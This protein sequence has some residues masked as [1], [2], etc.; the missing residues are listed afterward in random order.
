ME[1]SKA[2]VFL[3]EDHWTGWRHWA[4]WLI[5]ISSIIFLGAL[6]TETDAELAFAT[7]ALFP[8][9]VIAWIGGKWNGLIMAFLGAAMWAVADIASKRQFS[10]SWIP[11]ANALT[12]WGT[13]SLVSF[14][15]STVRQQF[16]NERE[17]ATC[18]GLTGLKNRRAFLSAGASEVERSKRYKHPLAVLFL[19]LDNFKQLNDTK[20]H[21]AGDVA[22]QVSAKAMLGVLRSSDRVARLG[23]DEFAILLPEVGYEE[24]VEAGHKISVSV[25]SSLVDFP[26]VT[27]SLGIAWFGEADRDF[28][29]MLKAA[30]ELM[31]EVK[32]S[33]KGNLRS[34]VFSKGTNPA[35]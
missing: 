13:Y 16:D 35:F 3:H 22:L 33:G 7:L 30:D 14:L 17:H 31:Y 26:P 19:D 10:T 5:C 23:G 6:R 20:G 32:A 21:D 34:R 9:L 29:L 2:S 18:D 25:N 24:A 11:W 1:E 8:V 12:R 28:L 4:A 27:A 15:A